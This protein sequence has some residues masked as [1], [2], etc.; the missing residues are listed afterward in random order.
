MRKKAGYARKIES[1]LLFMGFL[2]VIIL[3]VVESLVDT[4]VFGEDA[5][6]ESLFPYQDIHELID[7]AAIAVGLLVLIGFSQYLINRR[8]EAEERLQ[9]SEERF[10]ALVQHVS[11]VITI[12]EVDGTIRYVSPPIE[13]A[14][15]YRP[16]ELVGEYAF[17][18]IHPKDKDRVLSAFLKAMD[19]EI[20]IVCEEFRFRHKD[21]SWRY[22]EGIGTN[23]LLNPE[24]QGIVINSRDI[25]ERKGAEEKIAQALR[26]KSIFMAD[27]SHELRTPLT[28]LQGDAEYGVRMDCECIHKEILRRIIKQSRRIS[29]MV[30]DLLFL[31]RSD[32]GTL[33]LD[34][35]MVS[36][37]TFMVELAMLVEGLAKEHG[38]PLRTSIS[39]EGRL[40]I[41]I[42]RIEQTVLALVDNA[43]KYSRGEP[44]FFTTSTRSGELCIEITDRGP[45]IAKDEIPLIFERFHRSN[46][47][48][49]QGQPGSGLGLSIAKALAEIHGGRIEVASR[50]N[51]G[52]KM[53]LYLP[54]IDEP[55]PANRPADRPSM[56]TQG[57]A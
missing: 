38:A 50:V 16:E 26:A 36:I 40:R 53:A 33:P 34:L 21:G 10:R 49:S 14:L 24:I 31:A 13:R 1:N 52:T 45:G 46:K 6:A 48:K 57:K 19:E 11:D 9:R 35:R 25:T 37:E 3:W 18:Y 20:P 7:R 4:Y 39:G 47:E 30:E 41:D 5:L 15:G 8:F 12:L 22:F 32:S 23:L 44:V 56:P 55:Q 2:L 51:E 42:E 29:R 43:A 28:V 54:L 27:V 17:D